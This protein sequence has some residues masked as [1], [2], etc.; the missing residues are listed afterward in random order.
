VELLVVISIIAILAALLLP[1][2]A[3]SKERSRRASC[4]NSVRQFLLALH[5]YGDDSQQYLPSGASNAGANDD[6]LPMLGTNTYNL[7]PR[8]GATEQVIHCPGFINFF[9]SRKIEADEKSYGITIGYNYH[10]G[11]AHT[12]W[13]ALVASNVWLSPQLLTDDSSLV[14]ISDLNDW[15]P[16]Y[17]GGRTFV[18]HSTGGALKQG[19]DYGNVSA[20]GASPVDLGATGGNVG[21]LDGSVA[22][23]SAKK[24]LIYRG[25]QMYG[26][27]GCLAM[28]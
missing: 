12:P 21:L 26:A 20:G 25:S 24:M 27:D 11:H 22:W 19:T 4:K 15:S 17:E 8:Y 23:R 18:P 5:M 16:T 2:L 14:L 6:H 13:P 10:G 28:W 3:N 7:L 9:K 1:T